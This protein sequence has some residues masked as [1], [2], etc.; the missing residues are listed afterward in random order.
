MSGSS[1]DPDQDGVGARVLLLKRGDE[2]ER[3]SRH[4]PVIVVRRRHQR[5][6]VGDA[7]LDRMEGRVAIEVAEVLL[8][9]AR[10]VLDRPSPADRELVEA[11]HIH[12]AHGRQRDLEQVGTLGHGRADQQAA[13]RAAGDG[14]LVGR[15]VFLPDEVFGR[16]DEVVEDVLFIEKHPG[17]VPGFAVLAAAPEVGKGINAAVL[18]QDDPGRAEAGKLAYVESAVAGQQDRI[19]AVLFESF[20]KDEEH[21]DPRPVL[22]GVEDLARLVILGVELDRGP[23]EKL[24]APGG[25]IV[26]VDR[27]REGEGGVDVEQNL[28]VPLS[29]E[30]AG[31]AQGRKRDLADGVS[32]QVVLEDFRVGVLEVGAE[33]LAAG[34]GG[35]AQDLGLFGDDGG[36]IVLGRLLGIDQDDPVIR[37][38]DVRVEKDLVADGVDDAAV[39]G[40]P[41]H[42]DLEGRVL[43]V[44][45]APADL[46]ARGPFRNVQE[47]EFFVFGDVGVHVAE[48][49]LTVFKDQPVLVLGISDFMIKDLLVLVAGGQ[50]PAGRGRVIAAVIESPALPGRARELDPA[51]PV[52]KLRLRR[53]LH[54]PDLGPIGAGLRSRNGHVPVVMGGADQADPNRPVL[55][56]EV[57]IDE[58]L[59]SPV[60]SFLD[61]D[62]GLVLKAVVLIEE[63]VFPDPG[64]RR[65]AGIIVDLGQSPPDPLPEG[66]LLK[67]GEGH[68]VLGLD[69]GFDLLGVVVLEPAV[70][71]GDLGPEVI[72]D[73]VGL[74]GDRIGEFRRRR[75]AGGHDEGQSDQDKSRQFPRHE[76]LQD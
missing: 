20:P 5:R 13:V 63:I 7:V 16:G 43:G 45:G 9:V 71:V 57:G 27:G 55:G 40:E 33:E 12:D 30:S 17:F 69:P 48:G 47:K 11:E 39:V 28:L 25:D 56:Q 74:P 23:P 49:M 18:E 38:V 72:V 19:P 59:G 26:L 24:G 3:V 53:D 22:A 34:R 70:G 2:L 41:R 10:S 37:G 68:G 50:L 62:D 1:F 15:G 76:N 44:E 52:G 66:D 60:Q 36:P 64:R 6:R 29:V 4:D 65:V 21:R 51:D 46:V 42:Q 67:E 54:D 73:P 31:R 58:D 61:I 14:D 75:V 32:G 8:A 35:A